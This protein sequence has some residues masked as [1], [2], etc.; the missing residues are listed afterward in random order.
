MKIR[1][2][3]HPS[4]H[5]KI[6]TAKPPFHHPIKSYLLSKQNKFQ[7]ENP[8][9]IQSQT[10]FNLSLTKSNPLSFLAKNFMA[11]K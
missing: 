9:I 3:I 8:Q 11:N 5:Q 10:T 6:T 1:Q 2:P 7:S 4:I